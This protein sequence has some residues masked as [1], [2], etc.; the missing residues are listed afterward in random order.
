MII[1]VSFA[2]KK[3]FRDR[4]KLSKFSFSWLPNDILVRKNSHVVIF[5]MQLAFDHGSND[6]KPAQPVVWMFWEHS[7][8]MLIDRI[9]NRITCNKSTV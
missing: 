5:S 7:I 8:E 4:G 6:N 1:L 9:L 2:E 3:W